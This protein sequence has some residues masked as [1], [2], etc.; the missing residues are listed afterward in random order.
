LTPESWAP[1]IYALLLLM[2]GFS[3]I[4]LE[5]FVIP[6]INI[7]G[8]VGFLTMCAGVWYAYARLGTATAAV[9]AVLGLAGTALLVRLLIRVR[10]WHRI[11]LDAETSKQQGYDSSAPGLAELAGLSGESLTPLRP[12]GRAKFGERIVDVVTA[13]DFVSTGELIEVVEI[14]GNRVVVQK[15]ADKGELS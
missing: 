1:L 15:L 7:F 5:I 14:G 12:A 11:V 4:L 10:A 8:I 9:V 3:L 6:G 13:G 2:L